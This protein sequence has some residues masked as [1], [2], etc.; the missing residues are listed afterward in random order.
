M[1][2]GIKLALVPVAAVLVI[3][4][5]AAGGVVMSRD[6]VAAAVES[7]VRADAP[8]TVQP[9]QF[10]AFDPPLT[11]NVKDTGAVV[12]AGVSVSTRDPGVL[13]S[14]RRD[15]PALRS[16]MIL[17]FGEASEAADMTDAGKQ[18]LLR[19]ITGAVNRQ[20]AADGY[21]GHVDAAYFTDFIVQ[22]GSDD[23]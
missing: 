9:V 22:G 5:G 4:L 21:H 10:Y 12:Q 2:R 19:A 6:G 11:V 14:L 3:G 1:K 20:L 15:D 17:A 16:A 18:Q 8:P 23:Q 13:D 7:D